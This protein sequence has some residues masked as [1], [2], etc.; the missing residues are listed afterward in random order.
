MRAAASGSANG[1]TGAARSRDP[2]SRIA[3][4]VGFATIEMSG[5]R[6]AVTRRMEAVTGVGGPVARAARSWL[7]E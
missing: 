3:R 6:G 7:V 2:A 5:E 4:G 1:S